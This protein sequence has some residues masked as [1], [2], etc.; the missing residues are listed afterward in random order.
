[1]MKRTRAMRAPTCAVCGKRLAGRQ[2]KYCSRN[3]KNRDTNHRHQNYLSQQVRGFRRKIEMIVAA[4]GRCSR[5]GYDRSHAAL[6]WHH[7]EP[8]SK[9]FRLDLRSLSN[10]GK[11]SI[12][13]E[14]AKCILLCANCHAEEH[15]PQFD[16]HNRN[17]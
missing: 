7:L 9:S 2:R 6:T 1:M 3:C 16:K 5:C 11:R 13:A 17:L 8:S 12:D 15:F 14:I 4:G 10:R